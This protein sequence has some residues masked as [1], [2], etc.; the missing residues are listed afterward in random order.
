MDSNKKLI[1]TRCSYVN[2]PNECDSIYVGQVMLILGYDIRA[3]AYKVIK[4]VHKKIA[5]FLS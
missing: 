4:I 3:W 1:S 2:D 5:I